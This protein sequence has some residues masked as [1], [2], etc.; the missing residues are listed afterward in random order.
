MAEGAQEASVK[1]PQTK[2]ELE[3]MESQLSGALEEIRQRLKNLK[4]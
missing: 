2:E 1:E 3:L 4:D